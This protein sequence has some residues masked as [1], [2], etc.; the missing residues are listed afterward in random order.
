MQVDLWNAVSVPDGAPSSGPVAVG[1]DGS[2]A[3]ATAANDSVPPPARDKKF[4]Y[5]H[6]CEAL[7]QSSEFANEARSCQSLQS[8]CYCSCFTVPVVLSLCYCP[9]SAVPV[10]LSLCYS[11]IETYL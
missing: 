9:C 1:T 8:L 6:T 5:L 4:S 3:T 11:S 10:L 7:L 2:E